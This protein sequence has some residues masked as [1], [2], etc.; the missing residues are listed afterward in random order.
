MR[1]AMMDGVTH[2]FCIN[3]LLP[4][5]KHFP[6]SFP[7]PHPLSVKTQ[8]SPI[9]T[10]SSFPHPTTST[11]IKTQSSSTET[12]SSFPIPKSVKTQSSST[13]TVSSLPP[14]PINENSVSPPPRKQSP[15]SPHPHRQSIKLCLPPQKQSVQ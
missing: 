6:P 8:S 9:E 2:V 3:I 12:V 11:S 14:S 5:T 15:P 7:P 4:T 10:V 1:Y 13:V